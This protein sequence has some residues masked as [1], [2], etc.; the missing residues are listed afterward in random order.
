MGDLERYDTIKLRLQ[1]YGESCEIERVASG[2][3]LLGGRKE[4]DGFLILVCSNRVHL[5][6]M[7]DC[8]LVIDQPH[9]YTVSVRS[10]CAKVQVRKLRTITELHIGDYES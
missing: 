5:F 7:L 1:L 8:E 2:E 6:G 3:D 4:S 10:L 9:A